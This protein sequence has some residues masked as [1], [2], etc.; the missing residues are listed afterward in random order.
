ME[1]PMESVPTEPSDSF[2]CYTTEM[3]GR[4]NIICAP[5]T[6]SWIELIYCNAGEMQALIGSREYPLFSGDILVVPSGEVHKIIT[7]TD[8]RHCNIAVKFAPEVISTSM[9]LLSEYRTLLPFLLPGTQNRLLFHQDEIPS[10]IKDAFSAMLEEFEGM[11]YGY[12]IALKSHLYSI[13]LWL[14]RRWQESEDASGGPFTTAQ[15]EFLVSVLD[16]VAEHYSSNISIEELSKMH[17]ISYS[18]FS[19]LFKRMTGQNFIDYLNAV[20]ISAAERLLVT[21]DMQV[22][23]IALKVG[24]SDLSYFSRRF[25]EQNRISPRGYRQKY[26]E[27]KRSKR[28]KA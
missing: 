10:G 25:S 9:H 11:K 23:E 3:T 20:R 22:T 26:C 1:Y 13:V 5:H 21:T 17:Y 15:I 8:G 19:S 16:Y 7:Q 14:I 27:E 2:H 12:E 18:H 28:K 4:G 6:H 24:Y